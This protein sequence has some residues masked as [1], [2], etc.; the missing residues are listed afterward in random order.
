MPGAGMPT[1]GSSPRTPSSVKLVLSLLIR[2][3]LSSLLAVMTK[4]LKIAQALQ[5]LLKMAWA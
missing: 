3:P 1:Q 2:L 5:T 4:E